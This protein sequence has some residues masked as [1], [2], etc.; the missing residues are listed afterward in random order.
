MTSILFISSNQLLQHLKYLQAWFDFSIIKSNKHAKMSLS[1]LPITISPSELQIVISIETFP[2]NLPLLQTILFDNAYL[3]IKHAEIIRILSYIV[4]R[5]PDLN[6][7]SGLWAIQDTH[8][9]FGSL[10]TG[11]TYLPLWLVWVFTVY[12]AWLQ[13]IWKPA[14]ISELLTGMNLCFYFKFVFLSNP[15]FSVTFLPSMLL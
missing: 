11:A 3:W 4:D 12:H 10:H 14:F 1:I 9:L 8:T 5:I 7:L 13:E 2:R 6:L 15:S